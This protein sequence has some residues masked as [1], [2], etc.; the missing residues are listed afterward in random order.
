[1]SLGAQL[2]RLGRHSV[3]YGLGGLVSRILAVFLLPLYTRYLDPSDLGQVGLVVALSAVAVTVLRLGISSAF[4]RFYFDADDEAGR[5]IVV[6]TSFWFTLAMGLVGLVLGVAF[7]E[8]LSNALG[9]DDPDLIRAAALGVLAQMA[10]E[11][12]TS[13]FRAEERSTAFVAASLVNIAITIGATILLVVVWEQGALGVV[14]GN[15]TGT[16]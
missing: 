8:P 3:I 4:F 2:A 1:M 14:V 6:R 7:A 9:L 10:Y 12:Q 15:I 13:I 11:Q 16:L 5:R